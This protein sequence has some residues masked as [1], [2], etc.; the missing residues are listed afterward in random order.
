VT[1]AAP[2]KLAAFVA[3]LAVVGAAAALVGA[4]ADVGPEAAPTAMARMS[5]AQMERANGLTS[6]AAGLRLAADRTILRPG[7]S[8]LR[9]RILDAD[10]TP[11]RSFDREGGVELHLIL[12]RRDLTG[13]Q[14]LHPRLAGDTWQVAARLVAPGAYRAYADFEL[15]GEKTVL[16]TDL[17]VGGRFAP[18]PLPAPATRSVVDGFDVELAHARLRAGVEARVTFRI[19]TRGAAVRSFDEYVGHRGHL[20]ALHASDLA[21]THVHPVSTAAPGEIAFDADLAAAGRY[22]LFLQFKVHGVVH[23]A[24]FTVQVGG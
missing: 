4:A 18:R 19:R 7:R 22:R 5:S 21:Y 16:G 15:R 17:L 13:Y 3:V 24:A 6:S 8:L 9:F 10:G 12:V 23:T 1:L 11:V 14:H 20:V 2:A